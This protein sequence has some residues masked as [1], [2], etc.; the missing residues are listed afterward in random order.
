MK[1]FTIPLFALLLLLNSCAVIGGI[2]NAG[3]AVGIIG[4]II[5]IAIIFWIV[6]SVRGKS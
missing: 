2:F 4:V 5:V 3:A 6:S 1:R